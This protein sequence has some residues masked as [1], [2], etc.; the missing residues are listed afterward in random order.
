MKNR[1]AIVA[2]MTAVALSVHVAGCG[3]SPTAP[4]PPPT[5]TPTTSTSDSISLAN[6]APAPGTN[7]LPGQ[8]VTFSATVAFSLLSADSAAIVLGIQ[9]QANQRL[10]P[11]GPQPSATVAKGSGQAAL[12]QSI[13][14][15]STGITSV[16]VF[17]S[18]TPAGATRTDVVVSVTYPVIGGS[19]AAPAPSPPTSDSISLVNMAPAPGTSL[20]PGQTV[21]FTGT[22][23]YSLL[24]ADTGVIVLVIQDLANQPLQPVVRLSPPPRSPRAVVRRHCPSR[25]HCQAPAHGRGGFL[26]PGTRRYDQHQHGRQRHVSGAVTG[27]EVSTMSRRGPG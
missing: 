5:P 9:D 24:S 22:V 23:A 4:D 18:L 20:S 26:S 27:K 8:T 1:C 2:I 16:R 21:T 12:S 25:L 6:I 7:L 19:P 17:F 15:P 11:I 13:T 3:S 14:L 10:Q